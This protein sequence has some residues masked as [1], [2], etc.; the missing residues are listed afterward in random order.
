MAHTAPK[1]VDAGGIIPP[2][3]EERRGFL[4][5]RDEDLRRLTRLHDLFRDEAEGV[6][7]RFYEHLLS[8]PSLSQILGDSQQVER[9]KKL[10]YAYILS[11]TSGRLDQDYLDNRLRIGRAHER[12]GLQ[13]QWYMGAYG[14]LLDELCQLIHTHFGKRTDSATKT[15][16]ALTKL[17]NLDTQIV[18]H[19]Y[20]GTRQQKALEKSEQ[21]A[22]VG[23]LAASIAH[24]V[25][26]PLAGMK[27]ALEVLRPH[28]ANDPSRVEIADELL[29]QI[30]RL[31]NLVRDLLTY[32]RPRPLSRQ[33][34][35]LHHLLDRVVRI[36]AEIAFQDTGKGI[37]AADMERIF[38]PFFT[39]R[40]RGSG[41][42]LA[43][44]R[45][46]VERHGGNIQM[47]SRAAEGT[48]ALVLLPLEA[49]S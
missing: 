32:A 26:N 24:E 7:E 42:G 46:I 29:A 8:Y 30:E 41:L 49:I 37:K 9:L 36:V 13:P 1:T 48:T 44:V 10:Q 27:G 14:I 15:C 21:L 45:K 25:R 17:M 40:H 19:A 35:E 34:V 33:P 31:E 16:M 18:L 11:L 4:S 28:L 12:I 23:E 6:V 20:F 43:I 39:T 3:L 38:Q 2:E 47:E 5:L 22:A